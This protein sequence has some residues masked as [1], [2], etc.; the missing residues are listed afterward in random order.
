MVCASLQAT[1]LG[2]T[3]SAKLPCDSNGM[4]ATG[5]RSAGNLHAA[6]DEGGQGKPWPL[7]YRA[8]LRL[9]Q[10]R[11]SLD[12]ESFTRGERDRKDVNEG[13]A[14]VVAAGAPLLL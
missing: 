2:A 8:I 9:V 1:W 6:F 3:V 11:L 4:K 10:V 13:M 5:E 7:L 14:G 12:K